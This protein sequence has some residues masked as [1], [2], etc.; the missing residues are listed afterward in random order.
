MIYRNSLAYFLC[1]DV[2]PACMSVYNIHVWCP[3]RPVEGDRYPGTGAADS[4]ELSCGCWE[5]NL[6]PLEEQPLPVLLATELPLQL[7]Y[8]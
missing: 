7:T 6:G 4:C 1:L 3:R 5:L 2:L 8:F